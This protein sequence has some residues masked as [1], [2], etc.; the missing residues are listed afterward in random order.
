MIRSV[1]IALSVAFLRCSDIGLSVPPVISVED[2]L[3]VPDTV[4]VEGRAVTLSCELW[5]DFM[6]LSPPDGKPLIAIA[7]IATVDSMQ[8]PASITSDAVWIV[9]G[10]QVWNRYFTDEVPPG[11]RPNRLQ[12]VARNG[13]KWGPGVYVDVVVRL[14]DGNGTPHLLRASRQWIGRTD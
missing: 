3:A 4:V 8:L 14:S 2:L 9:F 6:P 12:K 5:R 10:S 1:A 7:S 11:Q 13:P